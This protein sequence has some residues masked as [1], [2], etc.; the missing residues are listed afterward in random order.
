VSEPS[1]L[2]S[3]TVERRGAVAWLTINRPHRLN[4]L[5]R[6]LV[7]RLIATYVELGAD[8]EVA[9][10]VITAVGTRAFCSGMDLKE[11]AERD[12]AGISFER[13]MSGISR[14]LYEVI[15]ETPRPTI[16]ALNGQA[17]G[18]GCEIALAC[19][20]RVAAED[21][22]LLLP[23]AQ[24]GLGANFASAILPRLLPRAI[25]LEML[26]AARPLRASE[27]AAYGLFNRVVP[28]EQVL[29]SADE[30]ARRIAGNAPLTIRR[31]KQMALRG[32]ELPLES[33]LR[34]D[35]GPDPYR[36]NDR[37]EGTRA[38]VEQR[39]PRWTGT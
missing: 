36:S 29:D 16:A 34:L 14:N 11:Q 30:L 15:L 38:F 35:L 9:V 28:S 39:P 26:Y 7:Q 24:R 3:L 1:D 25:A 2:G 33:A 19:D 6:A 18:A 23:E 8:R 22:D 20:L 27:A 21:A 10:I 4:A 17:I 12:A 32:W 31:Y 13:P 37:V 5:D